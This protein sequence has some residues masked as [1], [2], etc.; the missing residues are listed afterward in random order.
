M[1]RGLLICLSEGMFEIAKLMFLHELIEHFVAC[2][3][4][5]RSREWMAVQTVGLRH[6]LAL[7]SGRKLPVMYGVCSLLLSMVMFTTV[8]RRAVELATSCNHSA[9]GHGST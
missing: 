6:L 8:S 3:G 2:Q 1:H 5:S 9:H 4:L 7:E